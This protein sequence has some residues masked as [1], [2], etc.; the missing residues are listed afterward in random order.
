MPAWNKTNISKEQIDLLQ[1]KYNIDPISASIMVRRNIT[2]GKD[3]L[4]HMEDDLR[5]QHS[6]FQFT[7]MEDAVD[8]IID[9]A[10]SK[11]K[12]LIFGDRDVDGV[13]ATTVLYDCLSEMGIDVQYKLPKGDEAYGLSM[14]AVDEFSRDYGSLIITVDC[15]ISNNAEVAHA[16][17]LGLDVIIADHHNPQEE[18]P[19]PAIIINP[20]CEDS[21]YPFKD[22]SGCA[23][24]FK[25]VSALRFSRSKWYKQPVTL[26]NA[27]ADGDGYKIECIKIRNLVPVSRITQL[28]DSEGMFFADSKLCNYL[29][30]EMILAWDCA[31]QKDILKNCFGSGTEFNMLDVRDLISELIPTFANL[32]LSQI[33]NMSKI[34][35]YGNHEPTETGGLY[36]IYVTYVQLAF[37]KAFP[38]IKEK[39][40][41]D[42]QLVAL[43]ALADIMPMKNENR[44]FVR[45]ALNFMNTKHIRTGLLELMSALGMLEKHITSTD[46]SWVLVSNLNA[47]GRL[48]QPELAAELFI[49]DDP[50]YRENIAQKIK[51]CNNQRKQLSQDAQGYAALQAQ[52]SIPLHHNKLCVVIDERINRG[53]TG[54]IASRLAS[55]YNLPAIAVT[56]VD[57]TAVGSI[58]SSRG[59]NVA[60]FLNEL[61][62]IFINHGGHTFAGGFSF[63]RSKL[64]EF[65][66]RVTDLSQKIVL[67][68]NTSDIF[69]IDAQ[70]PPSY[71]TPDLLAISDRF[72]PFGEENDPLLFMTCGLLVTDAR[73]IGKSDKQH[74]KI[75]VSSG[76]YKWPAIFWNE[77]ER[78]HRDFEVNDKIDILFHIDRNTYNGTETPQLIL[79]DLRK[80]QS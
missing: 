15:G 46:L 47:A 17:E 79:E 72:E 69:N 56:F 49:S 18:L 57:D 36:N 24:V 35:K 40:E 52:T 26:L 62:D 27:Y 58:R 28:I 74:L 45:N 8:R 55:Q 68:E 32:S 6:P 42:L 43:A 78:L 33:K 2:D 30:G 44:I 19:S 37:K 3:L 29:Q 71:L 63:E 41:K 39:E 7:A 73:I 53:V 23:V 66:Q 20:K 80:S 13:S 77:S 14:A 65:E 75:E 34:A 50:V 61:K 70:I 64:S 10:E 76:K 54:I 5:F 1:K 31:Q 48:G 9:A 51:E 11:G 59:V 21:G 12:V 25:L 4:Y 38:D 67:S 60:D 16:A 22:I